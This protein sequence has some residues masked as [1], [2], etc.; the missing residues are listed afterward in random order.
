[1]FFR[2]KKNRR[3]KK[4]QNN[5]HSGG[6]NGSTSPSYDSNEAPAIPVIDTSITPAVRQCLI[7]Q[8]LWLADNNV[9]SEG[10]FCREL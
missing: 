5:A 4:G 8:P 2:D 3:D 6:Q 9:V 10:P 7:F 1:M